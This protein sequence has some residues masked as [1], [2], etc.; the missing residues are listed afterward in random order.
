MTDENVANQEY[1]QWLDELT[2]RKRFGEG[3]RVGTANLIDRA[4]RARAAGALVDGHCVSL[5]RPI[6]TGDG[7]GVH[8]DASHFQMPS[9]GTLPPFARPLDTGADSTR[10]EAHG[11]NYT[12]L[13]ALNHMGRD[14]K[15]YG[16][17]MTDTPSS[18]DISDLANHLLFTRGVVADI[19]AAR[20]AQWVDVTDPVTAEDIDRALLK[21]GAVFEPG[22]ALLLYMGRDRYEA[23]GGTIDLAATAGGTPA[24]GAGAGVARWIVEHDVSILA[25]D[26]LDAFPPDHKQPI[27]PVHLLIPAIGLLLVDNCHLGPAAEQVRQTHRSTGALIVAPP[28]IPGTTGAL[29]QPLFIQ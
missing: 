3:D 15:W 20:G 5:A 9:F 23:A 14:G 4:A 13:D 11:V 26:F 28:A 22:D 18:P 6:P 17:H 7:T 27:F 21:Q 12:H 8:I 29:V 24:N 25:W 19:P 16:G 10:I 2:E 1:G